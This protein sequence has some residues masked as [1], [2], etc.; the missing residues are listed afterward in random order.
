MALNFNIPMP[1]L[2]GDALLKGVNTGSN[3]MAKIMNAQYNSALHPSGDVANAMYVEQL[4]NQYGEND[5][6][7]LQAKAAHDMAMQGHQSLMDYRTQLSN[8]A[9]YRAATP[10]EKLIEAQQ[11]RGVLQTFGGKGRSGEHAQ[12]GM[13]SGDDGHVISED[14]AKVY[15]QALGKKTTDAATRNQIP[16]AKNVEITLD[17]I[18]P[19]DLVQFSGP[20]GNAR[21]GIEKIKAAF[22]TPSPE[23]L[24]YNKALT[25]AKMGAKQLRQFWK[26][27]IQPSARKAIE[28]L[29]NPTHWTKNPEIAKQEFEQLK[30]LTKQE[31]QTFRE[32]GTSPL[33]LDYDKQSGQFITGNQPK[34]ESNNPNL[35]KKFQENEDAKLLKSWGS[36]LTQM[37][38]TWTEENIRHTAKETGKNVGQVIQEL[39]SKGGR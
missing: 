39:M 26:D 5:P 23:L 27:S 4:K 8:L 28:E 9:P 10:E 30:A 17:S 12:A 3:M 20:E 25:S 2:P 34:S 37:N 1:E 11:G 15:N 29:T 7:Y 35:V 32:A 19:D 22:G 18:N 31:L 21:L 6:R 38:P 36:Q 16:F 33:K 13:V 24:A 14:E